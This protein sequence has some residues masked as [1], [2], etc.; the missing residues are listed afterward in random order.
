MLN[1]LPVRI[2][3]HSLNWL[4]RLV[5]VASAVSAV[6]IA[7]SIMALRYWLL[8][9]IEQYHDSITY[10]LSATIGSPVTIGKIQGE[11]RGFMPRLNLIDVQVLDD[12]HQTALAL[13]RIDGSLSW[14]SLLTAEIRMSS[15]EIDSPE[16][17][18]RR[19][20]AGK[21]YI[22]NLVLSRKGDNND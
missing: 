7:F 3:W 6:L 10:S 9:N 14:M 16:L 17:L 4:S 5:V 13:K 19:D 20:A 8:P 11:W 15:L 22:G 1:S 21:L 18:I 12:H 2:I